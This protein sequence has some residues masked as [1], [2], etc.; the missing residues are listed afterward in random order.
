MKKALS[1]KVILILAIF[2]LVI[3]CLSGIVFA[4]NEFELVNLDISAYVGKAI[5][6]IYFPVGYYL[7]ANLLGR[8]IESD[9]NGDYIK[10]LTFN[11]S[12]DDFEC[13]MRLYVSCFGV[14]LYYPN[15]D[16]DNYLV[17]GD[18]IENIYLSLSD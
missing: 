6:G 11:I 15:G 4:E 17:L 8:N 3:G 5:K 13:E 9:E 16:L 10:A 12:P 18:G 7:D 14:S 1:L 2:V